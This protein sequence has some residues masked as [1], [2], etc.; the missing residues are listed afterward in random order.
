MS[1]ARQGVG[2][3]FRLGE[4]W[5]N[6]EAN[7]IDGTRVEAKSMDVLVALVGAAPAVVSSAALLERV[8][9]DVVVVDN[10]V[11]QAVAQL[12]KA[13]GDDSQAPRYIENIPRRGYRLI[14]EIEH[15]VPSAVTKPTSLPTGG[16]SNDGGTLFEA[17]VKYAKSNDVYIAYRVFGEGPHDIV[18]VPGTISHVEIY[19]ELPINAYL[20]KRLASFARVIVFDKR[21]Q[22]LSDRVADM[23]LEERTGDLR[24]VMDAVGSKQA[25]IYGWSEG[26]QMCVTFSAM[27]PE[28]TVALVLFGCFAKSARSTDDTEKFLK[29]FS[30]HWGEGVSVAHNAPSRVNDEAFVQWFAR[31]ERAA[32]S[33]GSLVA[34]YRACYGNDVSH[35]LPSI[36]VP[37]LI[38]HRVGDSTVRV[39]EGRYLAEYIPGAKYVELPGI[40]HMLQALDQDVLDFMLD[41]IEDFVTGA[42]HRPEPDRVLTTLMFANIFSSPD[43]AADLGD[44]RWLDLRDSFLSAART[45]LAAC[46]GRE[47]NA[48]ADDGFLA[49]FDGPARAIRFARSLRDRL[50]PLGIQIRVGLH[51]GECEVRGDR[52]GGIALN[53]TTGIASVAS[54]GEILVSGTVK[55]LVAGSGLQFA[56]RGMK[57]LKG[58]SDE[59]RVLVVQ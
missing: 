8:W 21:G 16:A 44:R 1:R 13:L 20:L 12:R 47:V 24:A 49:S 19:W 39:E 23:T 59:W 32:A 46:Q 11:Y 35:L 28:R 57:G 54:A 37:T 22:G 40:D 51:T 34:L 25:T 31:F 9:P 41:E 45:E 43:I 5:V 38:L 53:I 50:R 14:A 27:Y 4:R 48:E 17:P 33:P 6:P 26:G 7:D 36:R 2:K 56:D 10:V 18:L 30:S 42:H 55:D 52:L 3:R 58:V 15:V 29:D